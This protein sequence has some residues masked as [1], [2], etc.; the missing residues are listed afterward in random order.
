V[1][2]AQQNVFCLTATYPDCEEYKQARGKGRRGV[3]MKS[4]KTAA[5]YRIW[6]LS[7]VVGLLVLAGWQLYWHGLSGLGNWGKSA[8]P[9]IPT[10]LSSPSPVLPSASPTRLRATDT[11]AALTPSP[12]FAT[13]T[14]TVAVTSPHTLETPIGFEDKL[15]IHRVLAGE[16]LVS[17]AHH[18]DTIPEAI[19]A[20]NYNLP[21]PLRVDW[22]VIIPADKAQVSGFPAFEA[23]QVETA[24][25]AE[26][27]ANYLSADPSLFKY[28]NGLEDNEILNPGDWVVVPHVGVAT[29]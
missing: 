2:L 3:G 1:K 21:S 28:Y 9:S 4:R 26:D 7:V 8:G 22:L 15:I 10:S 5:D 13:A 19:Q 27:L 24:S 16:S 6:V 11:P 29:P 23:Y 17:L 20:V 14:S 12:T 25:S 18:Y